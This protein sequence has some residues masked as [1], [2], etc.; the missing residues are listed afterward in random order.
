M[1]KINSKTKTLGALGCLIGFAALTLAFLSPWIA[2]IIDPPPKST[3]ENIVD[4]AQR[5]KEAAAAKAS[6][7]E[8]QPEPREKSPSAYLPPFVIALGLIGAGC[9]VTSFLKNENKKF[10]TTAIALGLSAATVQWSIIITATILAIFLIVL[11]LAALG[12]DLPI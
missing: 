12:I 4:F 3:E 9:G 1:E 6:G 7:R 8:Y 2:G 10:S 5:L 11:I